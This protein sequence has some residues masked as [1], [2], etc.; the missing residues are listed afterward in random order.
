MLQRMLPFVVD[1]ERIINP[2]ER[3]NVKHGG[4]GGWRCQP[5]V[6]QEEQVTLRNQGI[7]EENTKWTE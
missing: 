3:S 4:W 2:F 7:L 5:P 1:L 6:K